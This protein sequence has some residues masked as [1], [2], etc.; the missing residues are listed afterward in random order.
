MKQQ[1]VDQETLELQR[2]LRLVMS[3]MVLSGLLAGNHHPNEVTIEKAVVL[4]DLLI[5]RQGGM[6]L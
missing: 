6:P 3:T 1:H 2:T 4:T 5:E